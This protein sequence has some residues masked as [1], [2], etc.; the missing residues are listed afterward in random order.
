MIRKRSLERMQIPAGDIHAFLIL[1]RVQQRELPAQPDRMGR[2]N[3]CLAAGQEK[4]LQARVPK[5]LDHFRTVA[6]SASSVKRPGFRF[7]VLIAL[8]ARSHGARPI[9]SNRA[10]FELIREYREFKLKAW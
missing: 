8:T 7:D 9:T 3:S 1:G 4:P 2:L 6:R 10:D 5:R